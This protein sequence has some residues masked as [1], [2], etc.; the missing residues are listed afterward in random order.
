MP[1]V[2]QEAATIR[3]QVNLVN[4]PFSARDE[5]GR[6]VRDLTRDDVE[7]LED[8]VPQVIKHFS[9]GEESALSLGLIAD[10]SG[11]QK[12]FLKDHRRDL[13]DFL[14][15]VVQARDQAFLVGFGNRLRVV[16]ELTGHMEQLV[17]RLEQFQKGKGL[18]GL[19]EI[20]PAHEIRVLGTAFFDALYYSV[21]EILGR[22]DTGRRAM[23]VFS[24][25]E[26]NSSAHHLLDA[27]EMAQAAG[28]QLFCV[29]YTELQRK[30]WT[31]RNKY[32][33][34]VM[35]RI[36]RETGGLDL[37]ATEAENL[38]EPFRQIAEIL[39]A[40]YDLGYSSSNTP[41]G[42]FR[43]IQIRGKRA[44]LLFRHKTGYY[45]RKE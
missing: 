3:I 21:E 18:E 27:I 5:R 2:A 26:D 4:L 43:K 32:G 42:S 8:G 35:A 6:L 29:R 12:D 17:V 33:R 34:S 45:A 44:G 14:K 16:S 36:A 39:R 1:L 20:G 9:R 37:D 22:V 15:G 7:I 38:R 19:R 24:D 31:A 11:S 23:V 30:R 25:G 40:S 10:G 41:D 13:R 28:V